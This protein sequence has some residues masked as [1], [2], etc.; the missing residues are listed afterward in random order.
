MA[1]V[2]DGAG[3]RGEAGKCGIDT[4]RL[5]SL[6][7]TKKRT[8]RV[9][10]KMAEVLGTRW[11]W[12]W[13]LGPAL[14]SA[15]VL[16]AAAWL[17]RGIR[18]NSPRWFIV[19]MVLAMIALWPAFTHYARNYR[20]E[21]DMAVQLWPPKPG[22]NPQL[23]SSGTFAI[24]DRAISLP[25]SGWGTYFEWAGL[26]LPPGRM[27]L[28]EIEMWAD[29]GSLSRVQWAGPDGMFHPTQA[30]RF[31]GDVSYTGLTPWYNGSSH[32]Y[33]V[34]IGELDYPI[35]GLRLSPSNAPASTGLRSARVVALPQ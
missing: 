33:F 9:E 26:R 27:Y 22:E 21:F 31:Q 17:L 7:V 1:T 29:A 11:D 13:W 18:R 12:L 15:V 3:C 14:A 32:R 28:L 20:I 23:A 8:R 5:W 10:E 19:V 4:S 16:V 34:I 6:V 24:S 25:V 30:T 35:T 2:K